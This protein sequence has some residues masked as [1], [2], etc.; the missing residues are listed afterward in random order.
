MI[1]RNKYMIIVLSTAMLG[2]FLVGTFMRHAQ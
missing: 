2:G 1:S